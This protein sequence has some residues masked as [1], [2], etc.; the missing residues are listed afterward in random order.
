MG[1]P[2][3]HKSLPASVVLGVPLGPVGHAGPTQHEMEGVV[4]G[5]VVARLDQPTPP[6]PSP[7][8]AM[9]RHFG[10]SLPTMLLQMDVHAQKTILWNL[11]AA[12]HMLNDADAMGYGFA[13]AGQLGFRATDVVQLDT[14]FSTR[15]VTAYCAQFPE[16]IAEWARGN[17][18]ALCVEE[19]RLMFWP[20]RSFRTVFLPAEAAHDR[21]LDGGRFANS[22]FAAATFHFPALV[23]TI[24]SLFAS[25]MRQIGEAA[26]GAA[27]DY[28]GAYHACAQHSVPAQV[29]HADGQLRPAR[30]SVR[31]CAL[32]NGRM[33]WTALR[34][35]AVADASHGLTGTRLGE[36]RPSPVQ[37]RV[38]HTA[39][40]AA[41]DAQRAAGHGRA[42][43]PAAAHP[44]APLP[45]ELADSGAMLDL[46]DLAALLAEP[47]LS[48][49]CVEGAGDASFDELLTRGA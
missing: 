46:D 18:P 7:A 24:M 8:H 41:Y 20:N 14:S 19:G 25:C 48:A 47:E 33:L 13:L 26:R 10:K 6:A 9:L 1:R 37:A 31:A 15:H 32:D 35:E 17:A 36:A 12:A 3:L 5:L 39:S 38:A 21:P 49:P 29:P 2:P 28:P 27:S 23:T 22:P 30:L 44:A 42:Q 16:Y 43:P 34:I 4:A 11:V 45:P 40:A